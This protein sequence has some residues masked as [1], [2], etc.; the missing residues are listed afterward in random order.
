MTR[1]INDIDTP[2]FPVDRR[3]LGQNRYTALTLEVIRVHDALGRSSTLVEGAGLLQKSIHKR[4]FAVINMRD[5]R[6]IAN[7][8]GRKH[9]VV[10]GKGGAFSPGPRQKSNQT[11]V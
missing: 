2:L 1:R 4:G 5:N 7:F 9:E 8:F 6:D 10:P 11:G 3:V